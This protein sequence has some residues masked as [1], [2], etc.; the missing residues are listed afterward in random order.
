M[1]TGLSCLVAGLG[2]YLLLGSVM[3]KQLK[4][5][6]SAYHAPTPYNG[7]VTKVYSSSSVNATHWTA[8]LLCSGCSKWDGGSIDPNGNATFGWG[9]SSHAVE[10]PS[11]SSSPIRFHDIGKDHFELDM[12]KARLSKTDFDSLVKSMGG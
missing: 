6:Y 1:V 12:S 2:Q 7:T 9:V 11:S 3:P 4:G 8:N 10:T 5:I